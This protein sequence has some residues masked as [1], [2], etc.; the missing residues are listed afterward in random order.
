[1]KDLGCQLSFMQVMPQ[2]LVSGKKHLLEFLNL[3]SSFFIG[4]NN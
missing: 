2:A 3:V 4:A 1:M